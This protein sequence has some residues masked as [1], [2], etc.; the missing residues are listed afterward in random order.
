M[1]R[2]PYGTVQNAL[3][4]KNHIMDSR[5]VGMVLHVEQI[6]DTVSTKTNS[7]AYV[8]KIPVRNL[9]LA[10]TVIFTENLYC[11]LLRWGYI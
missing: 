6:V 10:A 5:S 1:G 8:Y 3:R 11:K 7:Q 9:Q 4:I 2:Y